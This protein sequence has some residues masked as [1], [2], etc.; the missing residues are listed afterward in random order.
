MAQRL[1]I[2]NA[3]AELSKPSGPGLFVLEGQHLA[4]AITE[5]STLNM[6]GGAIVGSEK[7]IPRILLMSP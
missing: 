3:I 5:K 6:A 7:T 1:G 4:A 2:V